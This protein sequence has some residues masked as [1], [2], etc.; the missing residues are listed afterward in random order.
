[1]SRALSAW[2]YQESANVSN[3]TG[4]DGSCSQIYN[5][6][7]AEGGNGL[8]NAKFKDGSWS[9]YSDCNFGGANSCTQSINYTKPTNAI[10]GTTM[11]SKIAYYGTGVYTAHEDLIPLACWNADS[12]KLLFKFLMNFDTYIHG[13]CYNGTAWV[14][15][16]TEG[17]YATG[18]LWEEAINW[19][20]SAC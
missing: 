12:N 2:C 14:T 20:V 9:T 7:F 1:V 15:F 17:T 18:R 8:N 3:Q 19:N 11:T 16:A 10:Y 6:T 5:G 4:I 13:Q